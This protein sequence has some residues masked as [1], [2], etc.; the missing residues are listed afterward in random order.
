ISKSGTGAVEIKSGYGL[1][2]EGEL[3]MLRVIRKLKE[4]SDL[5]I[6]ATFLGAHTYP[7]EYKENHQGYI[8][9]IINEMLPVIAKEK[10]AD[11][12]DVFCENGFFSAEETETICRAGMSYGLKPKLH[13][14]QLNS[15]GGIETGLKLNAISLD[16]LE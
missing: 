3:K 12:I 16:H 13:V 4:K 11:Y 6:K 14:N 7:L 1:S 10:L 9:L 5:S 2:V 8:D 15:I